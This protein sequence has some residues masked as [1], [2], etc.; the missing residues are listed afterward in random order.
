VRM[1]AAPCDRGMGAAALA[2]ARA[3]AA[4]L[5]MDLRGERGSALATDV[6]APGD[7]WTPC[8]TGLASWTLHVIQYTGRLQAE[9]SRERGGRWR[10]AHIRSRAF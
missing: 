6:E 3:R 2:R 5:V 10:G 7:E 9:Q 4:G 1:R 8:H